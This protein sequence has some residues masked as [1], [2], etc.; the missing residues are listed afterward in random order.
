MLRYGREIITAARMTDPGIVGVRADRT[1]ARVKMHGSKTRS[2]GIGGSCGDRRGITAAGFRHRVE[3]YLE[4]PTPRPTIPSLR[5]LRR[6]VRPRHRSSQRWG[7]V[8]NACGPSNRGAQLAE[9]SAPTLSFRWKTIQV[10]GTQFSKI[11]RVITLKKNSNLRS[12]SHK[13]KNSRPPDN[14]KTTKAPQNKIS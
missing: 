5:I 6:G 7:T 11:K 1:W 13:N 10:R 9:S 8:R 2:K 12:A 3:R 4:H 14:K